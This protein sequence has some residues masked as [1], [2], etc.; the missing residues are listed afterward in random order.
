[1]S[2][3]ARWRFGAAEFDELRWELR[4]AGKVVPMERKPL[5]VLGH[6]VRRAGE[7]V[8]KDELL[9]SAWAGRV[10]VE[11]ALSNAVAKLRRAIG[12]EQQTV[13]ATVPRIGYRLQATVER[14]APVERPLPARRLSVY[15][16]VG[17][18]MLA[19][20]L[21]GF[22]LIAY[23]IHPWKGWL[24]EDSRDLFIAADF[25]GGFGLFA[26]ALWRIRQASRPSPAPLAP[27]N[28]VLA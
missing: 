15:P 20:A 10:V 18:L 16:A 21:M 6:L 12:D 25:V 3:P 24:P 17:V 13:L 26:V 23:V 7:V 28:S 2:E 19:G 11:N 22:A 5:E 4:V 14:N 9:D 8:S 1:M 27:L